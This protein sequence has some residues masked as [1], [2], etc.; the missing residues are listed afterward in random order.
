MMVLCTRM[1]VDRA[2]VHIMATLY[3]FF[4]FIHIHHIYP[5]PQKYRTSGL[6]NG[7]NTGPKRPHA[8]AVLIKHPN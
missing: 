4:I 3:Q 6:A 7:Q 2:Y 8:R 5:R 1:A